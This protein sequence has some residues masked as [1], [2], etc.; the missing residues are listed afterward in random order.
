MFGI[1]LIQVTEIKP[2]EK[3]WT[4]VRDALRVALGEQLFEQL[5]AKQREK[6]KI[7]FA[8]KTPYFKP[9]TT[10]LVVPGGAK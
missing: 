9:G 7:E 6:S 3:K 4:D 1:H 2:G 10:E 8:G 5:A